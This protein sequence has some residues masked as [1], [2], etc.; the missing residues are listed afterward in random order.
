MLVAEMEKEENFGR[1]NAPQPRRSPFRHTRLI[2]AGALSVAIAVGAVVYQGFDGPGAYIPAAS[3]AEVLESAA[4]AI[5]RQ[6]FTA[7]RP[8]QF[9]YRETKGI[10]NLNYLDGPH[11]KEWISADNSRDGLIQCTGGQPSPAGTEPQII[12]PRVSTGKPGDDLSPEAAYLTL[13]SLP[14]EPGALLARLD[15]QAELMKNTGTGSFGSR[16]L[17]IWDIIR[18]LVR[19]APPAQ[20]A[21]LFRVAA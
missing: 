19:V 10:T 15:K 11:C 21:A 5:E 14:T 7:P 9:V 1:T 18:H 8:D 3:A 20:Q 13:A 2:T 6:S 16:T 12:S 4:E 17:L